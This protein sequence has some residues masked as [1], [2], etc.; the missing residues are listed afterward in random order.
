MLK[1]A[2]FTSSTL[3]FLFSMEKQ[4]IS[5]KR[6]LYFKKFSWILEKILSVLEYEVNVFGIQFV[7]TAK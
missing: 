7:K 2:R 4:E 5:Q 1:L 3:I 6:F